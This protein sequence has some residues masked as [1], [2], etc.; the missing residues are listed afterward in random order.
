M[1]LGAGS[2]E[3]G[4]LPIGIEKAYFQGSLDNWSFWVGKQTFPFEK[5][6]ELFWSDNVYPEGVFLNK[7]FQIHSDL[8]DRIALRGG[9]FILS[10]KGKSLGADTYFQGYQMYFNFLDSKFQLYPALYLFK[11]VPNIPD[12][13][14]TFTLDYSIVHLGAKWKLTQKP[15]LNLEVDY[16]NNLE[17]YGQNDS[18]PNR[19]KNQKTANVIGL[20]YGELKEKGNWFFKASYAYLQQYAAVDFMA[21]NDWARWD[22]SSFGSPDGRLTNFK[23][24]ELVAGFKLDK[25]TN[26][27]MKY[28]RVA[29]HIPYGTTKETGSRIRLDLDVKF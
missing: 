18:I 27:K 19:F 1:T 9:H 7:D 26:L 24:V 17:D 8:V 5:Q 22:Y 20:S 3:F 11:N 25:R 4:T 15:S 10:T 23:G 16:Y 13:N 14:G 6:N 28:Y 12:G 21:Q 29:Q 2:E